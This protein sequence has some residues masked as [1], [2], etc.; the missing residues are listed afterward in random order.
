MPSP[1]QPGCMSLNASRRDAAGRDGTTQ[2]HR[3][4]EP[5]ST[6]TPLPGMARWPTAHLDRGRRVA[7]PSPSRVVTHAR[8]GSSLAKCAKKDR[9]TTRSEYD[10]TRGS[11]RVRSVDGSIQFQSAGLNLVRLTPLWTRTAHVMPLRMVRC[12]FP[13]LRYG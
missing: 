7:R 6:K 13:K 12:R 2:P 11:A 10:G 1:P 4:K 8:A 3:R 9:D 5:S